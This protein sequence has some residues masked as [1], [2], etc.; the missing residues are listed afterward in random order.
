MIVITNTI[1][2]KRGT[3]D[4]LVE[5]FNRPGEVEK[6]EG[7]LGLDLLQTKDTEEYDEYVVFT[8]WKSKELHDE[9][10][11]GEAFRRSHSGPRPD[12]IISTHITH[13]EVVGQRVPVESEEENPNANQDANQDAV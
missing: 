4:K 9:W 12:Y 1:R 11:K 13:Y 2:V 5:R 6:T 3:G 8:K 10:T 7:F